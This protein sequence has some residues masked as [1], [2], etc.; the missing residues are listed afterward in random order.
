MTQLL[1]SH[2]SQTVPPTE[3][4]AVKYISPQWPF[5]FKPPEALC[6]LYCL[7]IYFSLSV[8]VSHICGSVCD[9]FVAF[10]SG[11][12][13]LILSNNFHIHPEKCVHFIFL[14]PFTF[15]WEHDNLNFRTA[16]LENTW[17]LGKRFKQSYNV[18]ATITM[19]HLNHQPASRTS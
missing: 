16:A 9:L 2:T 15:L 11:S 1:P 14:L 13:F 3:T 5:S 12:S 19:K 6:F 10:L 4:Q 17:S 7:L 18:N 8:L